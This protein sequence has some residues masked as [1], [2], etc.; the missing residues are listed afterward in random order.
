MNIDQIVS[1]MILNAMLHFS[2]SALSE[3]IFFIFT[4]YKVI[5]VC[6][7]NC[8]MEGGAVPGKCTVCLMS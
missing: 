8:S 7:L 5:F 1:E 4:N 2:V 6:N 3:G